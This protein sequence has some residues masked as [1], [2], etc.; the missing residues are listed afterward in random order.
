[1]KHLHRV[2]VWGGLV[3]AIVVF[4]GSLLTTYRVSSAE[5]ENITPRSRAA[6]ISLSS[7][8]PEATPASTGNAHSSSVEVDGMTFPTWSDYFRST[9]FQQNGK[10]C[11]TKIEGELSSLLAAPDDCTLQRT[12]IQAEYWPNEVYV[13]PIVFHIIL[14]SDGTGD[15]PDERIHDQVRV[16]NEDYQA[17]ASTMGADGV[18]THLYFDL[19]DITRTVNDQWF[20]DLNEEEFKTALGW[21]QRRFLNGAPCPPDPCARRGS[22]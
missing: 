17:I 12:R 6:A 8:L 10:R 5:A 4:G 18:N 13:I 15:I 11:G 9:Y 14:R 16:L 19:T 3:V 1:M 7:N 20:D 21:D 2:M 22:S